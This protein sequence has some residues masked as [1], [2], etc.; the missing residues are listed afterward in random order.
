MI[1]NFGKLHHIYPNLNPLNY[2]FILSV[3]QYAIL[4]SNKKIN[5]GKIPLLTK[6]FVNN[7]ER[8]RVRDITL[9][10]TFLDLMNALRISTYSR[11]QR[12]H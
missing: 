12:C 8:N 9:E 4:I 5:K 6:D 10:H 11:G 1:L 7:T 3:F 2:S